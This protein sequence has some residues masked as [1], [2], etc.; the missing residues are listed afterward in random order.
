MM[1]SF[2][3]VRAADERPASAEWGP[4]SPEPDLAAGAV[5]G[6]PAWLASVYDRHAASLYRLLCAMLGSAADAED[7]LQELFAR[8][9]D[10]RVRRVTD[11]KAYLYRAARNEALSALRRRQREAFFHF[12]LSRHSAPEE[13]QPGRGGDLLPLLQRLPPEQREVVALKVFEELTFAEIAAV[14]KASPNTVAAR[15][16]YAVRKLRTWVEEE[17]RDGA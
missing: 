17:E 9:A 6:D 8:L 7:A 1:T 11:L 16:R 4:A 5:Q 13:G 3:A 10:G 2:Q 14:V 12:R 15:Y